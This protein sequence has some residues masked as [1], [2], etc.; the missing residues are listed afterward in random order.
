MPIQEHCISLFDNISAP[1]GY[2]STACGNLSSL[3]KIAEE[4]T[5]MIILAVSVRPLIQINVTP[6]VLNRLEDKKDQ[7]AHL[8]TLLLPQDDAPILCWEADNG[9]T[10]FMLVVLY[11]KL[12][13]RFF[14]KGTQVDVQT[15]FRVHAK[16]LSKILSSHKYYGST[17]QKVAKKRV[18]E[19]SEGVT[20]RKKT[21]MVIPDNDDNN[22]DGAAAP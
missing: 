21:Q 20:K 2:M 3:A 16:Q 7:V 9:P 12:S 11:F 10:H 17:D 15:K 5:F 22:S 19:E 18:A 14:N 8:K 4:K 1:T 13:H 6:G